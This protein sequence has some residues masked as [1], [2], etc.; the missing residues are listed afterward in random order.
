LKTPSYTV[1]DYTVSGQMD[2][3]STYVLYIQF[4]YIFIQYI[5]L[6]IYSFIVQ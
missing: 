6:F 5:Y 4:T 2:L 1:Y 3:K